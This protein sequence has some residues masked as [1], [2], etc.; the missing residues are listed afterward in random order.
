MIKEKSAYETVEV[1]GIY[2]IKN[3]SDNTLNPTA[4]KAENLL[5]SRQST[6]DTSTG[7]EARYL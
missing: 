3:N 1:K 6:A 7:A 4:K 5:F 2:R